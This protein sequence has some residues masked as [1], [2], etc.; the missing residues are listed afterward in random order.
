MT[1]VSEDTG[2][3]ANENKFQTEIKQFI[4]CNIV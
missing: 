2:R 1:N 4:V 3:L